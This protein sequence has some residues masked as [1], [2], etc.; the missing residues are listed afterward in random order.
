MM[1]IEEIDV[2]DPALYQQDCWYDLF[3]RLRREAPVHFCAESPSGPFWSVTKYNDIMAVETDYGTY[4][5]EATLGGV[6]LV[7]RPMDPKTSSFILMDPPRHTEQR[8]TV[9]P[10]FT[11]C[12]PKT[13]KRPF[14]NAR[15]PCSTDCPMARPLLGSPTYPSS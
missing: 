14:A 4:S 8:K 2:S 11:P 13:W 3:A 9:A 15:T 7:E 1:P 5:S 6:R 12:T 10:A